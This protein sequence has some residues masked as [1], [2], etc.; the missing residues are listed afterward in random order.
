[1]ANEKI[2]GITLNGTDYDYE[3]SETKT[4]ADENAA[5]IGDLSELATEDKTSLVA[6]VNEV[7]SAGG[8]DFYSTPKLVYAPSGGD[9]DVQNVGVTWEQMK[10]WLGVDDF[11]ELPQNFTLWVQMSFGASQYSPSAGWDRP[12]RWNGTSWI[13]LD[14]DGMPRF[15]RIYSW[16]VGFERGTVTTKYIML[17]MYPIK[18][19]F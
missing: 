17:E 12:I 1:M 3:D 9:L 18:I 19:I 2:I 16:G 10:E 6:A 4:V 11:S 13:D 14:Y 5:A 7:A 15:T 8:K